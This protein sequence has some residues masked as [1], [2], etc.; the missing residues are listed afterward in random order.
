VLN[1]QRSSKEVLL[2]LSRDIISYWDD[3]TTIAERRAYAETW[4]DAKPGERDTVKPKKTSSKGKQERKG[5]FYWKH[6]E[7]DSLA[8]LK[9]SARCMKSL[10]MG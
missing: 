6:P 8:A 10:R 7:S 1:A 5:P 4:L 3:L 9:T 2:D